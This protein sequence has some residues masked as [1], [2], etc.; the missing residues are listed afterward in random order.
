MRPLRLRIQDAAKRQGIPQPVIEK[1]YASIYLRGGDLK[2]SIK[3]GILVSPAALFV[4]IPLGFDAADD[5][6]EYAMEWEE[7]YIKWYVDGNLIY[8]AESEIPNLPHELYMNI[9][10]CSSSSWSGILYTDEPEDRTSYYD[11]VEYWESGTY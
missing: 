11:S 3:L 2:Q 5:Y 6:H 10:Y 9:W 4:V 1:D 7:N 8:T